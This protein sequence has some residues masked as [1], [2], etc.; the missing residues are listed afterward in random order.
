MYTMVMLHDPTIHNVILYSFSCGSLEPQGGLPAL[1]IVS[2]NQLAYHTIGPL[3]TDGS[4]PV[5][6]Q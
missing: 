4:M 1:L 5:S 3:V 6:L 2:I